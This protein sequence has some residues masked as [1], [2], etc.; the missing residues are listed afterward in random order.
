MTAQCWACD[1]PVGDGDCEACGCVQSFRSKLVEA[2][3]RPCEIVPAPKR[4]PHMR[5]EIDGMLYDLTPSR[6]QW[7]PIKVPEDVIQTSWP[8]R[9]P[10]GAAGLLKRAAE[11]RMTRVRFER[12]EPGTTVRRLCADIVSP[13]VCRVLEVDGDYV[14]KLELPFGVATYVKGERHMSEFEIVKEGI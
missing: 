9:W 3:N 14:T 5:I 2:C 12:L 8:E 7:P 10:G 6:E 4:A 13:E 1:A 11:F